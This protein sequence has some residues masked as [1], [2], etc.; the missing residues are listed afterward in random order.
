MVAALPSEL[1]QYIF[2]FLDPRSVAK[3]GEVCKAWYVISNDRLRDIWNRSLHLKDKQH[4]EIMDMLSRRL[5]KAQSLGFYQINDNA[6][7]L[8]Q[9]VHQNLH[10][11]FSFLD[12][13]T[14]TKAGEISKTWH[15]ISCDRLRDIWNRLL[16]PEVN[17]YEEGDVLLKDVLFRRLVKAQSLGIYQIKDN[18]RE[19]L[20]RFLKNHLGA[21][22]V[23]SIPNFHKPFWETSN[24]K[25]YIGSGFNIYERRP[26]NMRHLFKGFSS[27]LHLAAEKGDL[28]GIK[29]LIERG[30]DINVPNDEG[31]TPIFYCCTGIAPP[32]GY[33][34][35]RKRSAEEVK[36]CLQYLIAHGAKISGIDSDCVGKST[37]MHILARLGKISLAEC[38]LP[39]IPINSKDDHNRTPLH[40]ASRRHRISM[41]EWLISKGADVNAVDCSGDTPLHE[42]MRF[43]CDKTCKT[44]LKLIELGAKPDIM[45]KRGETPLFHAM[46]DGQAYVDA[47][48]PYTSIEKELA[49]GVPLLEGAAFC[50]E[51]IDL[52]KD[53]VLNY[54][55]KGNS[56]RLLYAMRYHRSTEIFQ[57]LLDQGLLP[58]GITSTS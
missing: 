13:K 5:V 17:K 35:S 43:S 52:V 55:A 21:L 24:L 54:K 15:R 31:I 26:V 51:N 10:F 12:P 37:I 33:V 27:C 22:G 45:N 47:L 53:L 25:I 56:E 46:M 6:L 4:K 14:V 1:S 36:K 49:R 48:K 28:K 44:S 32:D 38:I 29:L 16:E 11:L 58:V 57:F 42:S 8:V 30:C 34:D 39:L 7:K 20:D 41:V 9:F 23:N 18:T 19:K 3:A 50:E 2:S 40:L